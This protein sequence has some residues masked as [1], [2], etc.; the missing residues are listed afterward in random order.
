VGTVAFRDGVMD[1]IRLHEDRYHERAYLF[2][3]ASLEFLQARL[4]ERRHVDGRELAHAVRDLA[5]ER[6]GVLASLVLEH[7]G[8]RSTA[9]LGD[10]VFALV[11][12]GLLMSL[13]TDSRLDFVD[14]FDFGEAFGRSYPWS[15]R[16]LA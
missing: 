2:V 16:D 11:D 3:L 8:V 4:P 1:L 6:F 5:L 12:A 14:V 13:P 15:A 10:V 7:W 9:D